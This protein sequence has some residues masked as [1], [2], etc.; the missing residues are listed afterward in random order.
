MDNGPAFMEG[1]AKLI[2]QSGEELGDPCEVRLKIH[3]KNKI[4]PLGLL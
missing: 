2:Q 1:T 4:N 3:S